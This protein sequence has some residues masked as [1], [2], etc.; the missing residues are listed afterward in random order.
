MAGRPRDYERE[1]FIR[2]HWTSMGAN[3][4][5]EH[6]NTSRGSILRSARR[7]GLKPEKRKQFTELKPDSL[8]IR[9]RDTLFPNTVVEARDSPRLL[10]DGGQ[11]VKLGAK[12][13]KG[14]WKGL[15]IYG[16]TLTE[17]RTCPATC[18]E[19]FTCYGNNMPMARRHKL[20]KALFRQLD[21][22]VAALLD[23][24]PKGILVRLHVLGDF[25]AIT[26]DALTYIAVWRRMMLEHP[27]LHLFG[28]TAHDPDNDIGSNILA[29]NYE[30]PDRCRIRFS[31]TRDDEGFGAMVIDNVHM[32][33]AV[34]CPVELGRVKNCG[35]CGLCWTMSKTVEFVR[36]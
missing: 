34:V 21:L 9:K 3:R 15:A 36:H 6:F 33:E 19:W 12:V 13:T 17:R 14:K 25:G 30:F 24:H 4:L 11:S 26:R 23:R 1:E 31:N 32:R 29:L 18:A 35:A 10:V 16:L 5:A 28:F 27:R 22:E 7:I 20:G 2:R 8:A